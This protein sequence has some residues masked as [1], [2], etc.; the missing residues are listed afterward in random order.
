MNRLE[1]IIGRG[2]RNFSHKDLPFLKLNVQIFLYGTYLTN[3]E[4]EAADLYVYRISEIKAIK[5]G[6]VTRL[7]KQISVDCV[8]NH[9]QSELTAENLE[10]KNPDVNQLLS[11]HK[12]LEHFEVGDQPNSATC[13]YKCIPDLS[14]ESEDQQ[15]TDSPFNLNTYNETFMLI[16]SDKI[17]QKIKNL[18][19]DLI[20]GRFFYKKKTLFYLINMKRKYPTDQIYAALT[21]LIN[22]NSEYITDKYGRT[23]H[24]INIGEYYLFQ[25]SELNYPNIS[26]FDRSRPLEYKHD[27]IKFEIKTGITNKEITV[28][29]I[30]LGNMYKKYTT[31]MTTNNVERGTD[32]WYQHCG[33]VIRKMATETIINKK[34]PLERLKLLLDTFVVQHI[35]DTLT[36]QERIDLMNYLLEN[37]NL[38]NETTDK[39]LRSFIT[40]IKTYLHSKVITANRLTSMVIFDGPSKRYKEVVEDNTDNGNLNIFVL[41]EAEQKWVPAESED[42]RDLERAIIEH[43]ELTKD[44]KDNMNKFVGFVGFETNQKDMVFKIKDTANKRS[45]GFRCIQAGKGK[46]IIDILNEIEGFKQ[47]EERFAVKESK[48][49]VYELCIRIELTLRS[50]EY[51]KLDDVLWF[52]DTETA[53]FNEFEK[54]EKPSK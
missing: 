45:T 1:Q 28:G 14:L 8:I 37:N 39:Y 40:N 19:S 23:G 41:K 32:D 22:D 4:E 15:V 35:V 47:Q 17:I 18:F 26:V 3:S 12:L 9:E 11:N 30:V 53:I 34:T 29:N 44:V 20:D 31:A 10:E 13:E 50:Y 43:Y 2:V 21:Q 5:I 16:N 51:E 38:E 33:I 25:P 48:E 6:K 27:R 36:F 49:S 54:R 24:L 46:K 7:L 42:K 52:I